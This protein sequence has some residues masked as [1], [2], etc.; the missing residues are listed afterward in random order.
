MRDDKE[1][2]ASLRFETVSLLRLESFMQELSKRVMGGERVLRDMKRRGNLDRQSISRPGLA[3]GFSLS[4]R[5]A[6]SVAVAFDGEDLG[7]MDE[8]VNERNGTAGVRKDGRPV[9]ERQVRRDS[10]ESR[11]KL[12]V[13]GEAGDRK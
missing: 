2:S 10:V 8:A 9:A 12:L 1:S 11:V 7:V 13:A 5:D 4:L 6:A 3:A